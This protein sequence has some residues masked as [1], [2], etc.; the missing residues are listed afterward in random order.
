MLNEF[1]AKKLGEVL[2]FAQVS[3]ETLQ[4]GRAGF[5][6]ILSEEEMALWSERNNQ[7]ERSIMVMAEEYGVASVTEAKAAATADKLRAMRDMYVKDQWDNA[8]ELSEWSG[9]FEGAAIVHWALV[10][11]IGEGTLHDK[12]SSLANEAKTYHEEMLKKFEV[13]LKNIGIAKVSN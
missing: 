3:N 11:G 2:A 8:A 1:S 6:M 4:K 5:G 9:F 12:I 7:H 13:F 10:E